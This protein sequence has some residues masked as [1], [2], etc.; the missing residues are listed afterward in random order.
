MQRRHSGIKEAL[1]PM[2]RVSKVETAIPWYERL[3]FV[4]ELEHSSGPAFS[5]TTAVVRRGD[6]ALILSDR[7]KS[8]ASDGIVYL[9]VADVAPI[10]AEF[11]VPMQ[12]SIM[13]PHLELHDPDGN[14]IRVVADPRITFNRSR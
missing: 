6:L 9:R 14:L 13:G 2:L 10:A 4:L 7:D 1:A 11:D 5:E 3:G 8:V 12:N